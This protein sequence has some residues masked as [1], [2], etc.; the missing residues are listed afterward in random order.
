[1]VR[2]RSRVG[3]EVLLATEVSGAPRR[4]EKSSALQAEDGSGQGQRLVDALAV[5]YKPQ[6]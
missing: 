3:G 6:D 1:M 4:R 5:T 2:R